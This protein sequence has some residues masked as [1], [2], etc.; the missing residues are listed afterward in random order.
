MTL[1]NAHPNAHLYPHI[2]REDN[3]LYVATVEYTNSCHYS[4]GASFWSVPEE[5]EANLNEAVKQAMPNWGCPTSIK[6]TFRKN[7]ESFKTEQTR[8]I[9]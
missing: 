3:L 1:N 8:K 9:N 7:S 2:N 4:K 5:F 6:V